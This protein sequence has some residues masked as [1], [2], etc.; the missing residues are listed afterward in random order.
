M[1]STRNITGLFVVAGTGA[2]L[3][4]L[5]AAS[6]SPPAA[7]PFDEAR[8]FVE[9]NAT[10]GDAEVVIDID[11]DVGLERLS[12]VKPDGKEVLNLRAK[13]GELGLRKFA[14]ETPEPS[15]KEV[16]SAYPEGDYRFLGRSVDGE[17]LF[18]VVTLSHALP[19]PPRLVFPLEGDAGVPTRGASAMWAADADAAG[20]FVELEND[21]LGTDVKAN[22]AGDATSFGFPDGFLEPFTEYQ[23][24]LG[25]RADNDNLTVVE[26]HFT[27]GL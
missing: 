25:S 1:L 3:A 13:H 20:F 21:D 5:G 9:Y 11:A 24:G 27:T 19:D 4:A 6:S 2:A 12:I 26:V 23:F 16:L 10:D 17:F 8:I 22:L 18:S 7:I 15:L 14:L